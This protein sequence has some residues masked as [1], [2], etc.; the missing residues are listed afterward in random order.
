MTAMTPTEFDTLQ[1]DAHAAAEAALA[2]AF[3]PA[4]AAPEIAAVRAADA[5][6]EQLFITTAAT[7][8]ARLARVHA[9]AVADQPVLAPDGTVGKV[10]SF[11]APS[12]DPERVQAVVAPENPRSY[13][14][15]YYAATLK[16]VE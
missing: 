8:V 11:Y 16:P 14:R 5:E 10:K 3:R 15:R 4:A 13:P 12:A 7:V 1:A 6:M 2:Q 9:A